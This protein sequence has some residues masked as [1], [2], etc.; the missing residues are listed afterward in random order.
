MDVSFYSVLMSVFWSSIGI[1]VL[2]CC[3]KRR[4]F[5]QKFGIQM[6]WTLYLLCALR[7]F[8]PVE[9]NGVKIIEFEGTLAS[10]YEIL[11]L[12]K[13][14]ILGMEISA[15]Q[16]CGGIWII[17]AVF[18]VVRWFWVYLRGK[19]SLQKILENS[20]RQEGGMLEQIQKQHD[21]TMDIELW[22]SA[23]VDIPMGVGIFKKRILIPN[24][25]YSSMELSCIL[26]HEYTHF[27]NHDIE[28]KVLLQILC[29][30]FWWNPCS[31]LLLREIEQILEIRCD[32]AVTKAMEKK[33]KSAY[34][35]TILR[36][37]QEGM[38]KKDSKSKLPAA[39]L[40]QQGK[41]NEVLERF[42]IV[43][44]VEKS[45]R[46][47]ISRCMVVAFLCFLLCGSY[48]VQFQAVFPPPLI[49]N[50][51]TETDI[52]LINNKDGTYTIVMKDKERKGKVRKSRY[53]YNHA[54]QGMIEQGVE[55][56]N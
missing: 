43:K 25:D 37:L 36:I 35:E 31:Y 3:V 33:E 1:F 29:C 23:D 42:Q 54:I 49:E 34:L 8:C 39:M 50:G 27:R 52:Y 16:V 4:W 14:E 26:C 46:S 9:I 48:L 41:I 32:L 17:G 47:I 30:V 51:V 6:L 20:Q 2:Y 38:G 22:K 21:H 56:R 13:A 28:T 19:R 45:K 44:D 55:V 24:S 11:G 40:F 10:V 5:I 15:L 18:L 53:R 7:L 12:Q